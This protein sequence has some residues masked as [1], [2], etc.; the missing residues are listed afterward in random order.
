MAEIQ[1]N[2]IK[3]QKEVAHMQSFINRFK[4]KATKARQA[5]DNLLF[6]EPHLDLI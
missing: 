1:S 6:F 3:Q 5:L 2:F 4:A